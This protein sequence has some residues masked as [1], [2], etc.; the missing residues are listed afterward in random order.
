[1]VMCLVTF[2]WATTQKYFKEIVSH[3]IR[4]QFQVEHMNQID[5]ETLP[6]PIIEDGL[7]HGLELIDGD[8]WDSSVG[9][10]T[11]GSFIRDMIKNL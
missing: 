11:Y 7:N 5:D 10:D 1:L 6:E 9:G 3:D 8:L 4:K 2:A